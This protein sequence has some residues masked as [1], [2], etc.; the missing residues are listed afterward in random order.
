MYKA[1]RGAV[2]DN[3]SGRFKHKTIRFDGPPMLVSKGSPLVFATAHSDAADSAA[4]GLSVRSSSAEKFEVNA[5]R[6][7]RKVC[8]CACVCVCVC[9]CVHM[10]VCVREA[11][12]SRSSVWTTLPCRVRRLLQL[13][14]A[15]RSSRPHYQVVPRRACS[16]PLPTWSPHATALCPSERDS[17]PLRFGQALSLPPSLSLSLSLSLAR[18]RAL[19]PPLS[20]LS[21]ADSVCLCLSR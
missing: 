20:P 21:L 2:H 4:F 6:L 1:G 19:S 3:P 18:S 12:G 14:A 16:R 10:S 7:D 8:V 5:V 9:V 15:E 11:A 17:E 13:A